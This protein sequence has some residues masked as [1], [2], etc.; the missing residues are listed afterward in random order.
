MEGT[1]GSAVLADNRQVKTLENNGVW[2]ILYRAEGAEKA[3]W[4]SPNEGETL[5]ALV[6]RL[7]GSGLM[8]T[9]PKGGW[10]G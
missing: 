10:G 1:L 2:S 3:E 6:T 9:K 4:V 8:P 5:D 7:L